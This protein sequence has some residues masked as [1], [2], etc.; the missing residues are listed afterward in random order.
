MKTV[1]SLLAATLLFTGCVTPQPVVMRP[2]S[3]IF[4]AP[5]DKVWPA[6]VSQIALD[7]PVKAIEKDSGLLTTDF[8]SIPC[9]FGNM[10]QTQWIVS[11]EGFLTTF[12]GLRMNMSVL[13]VETEPGKTQITI[14]THYE[15]YESNVNKAWLVCQSNG[16]LENQILD[17]IAGNLISV[18]TT[19]K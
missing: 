10:N 18:S 1:F 7:Y 5:K 9:G 2:T 3:R 15:A 16:N 17:K 4:N 12:D 6:V 14:R 19:P 11:P 13:A 8:I